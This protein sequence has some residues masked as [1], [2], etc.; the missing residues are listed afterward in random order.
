VFVDVFSTKFDAASDPAIR[1]A[2]PLVPEPLATRIDTSAGSCTGGGSVVEVPSS[3]GA[4]VVVVFSSPVA[5]AVN[6]VVR[7]VERSSTTPSRTATRI[8]ASPRNRAPPADRWKEW[9]P[10]AC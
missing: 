1:A 4:V 5:V 2:A 8:R 3:S 7:S 9:S 6:G 10:A